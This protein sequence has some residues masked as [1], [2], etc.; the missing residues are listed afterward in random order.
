[1][2]GLVGAT[3]LRSVGCLSAA[4]SC[5]VSRDRRGATVF[6]TGDSN[7]L[8]NVRITLHIFRVLRPGNFR[9]G[10]CGRS[11]SGLMGNRV[12][13]RV[14]NGAEAVLGNREATLGLVRRVD[15]VT[16]TAGGTIRVIDNA[17]TSVTSAE[18]ALP[19][20]HPLRGCTIAIKNKEGRHCGLSSTTVLGSG[21]VSTNNK[22][23]G[24][25][26]GL[27]SG[28]NRVAGIRLRMEGLSRL[29]RTLRTNI[30]I[31]VLSGVDPRLV[32]RTISVAT[33]GTLLR[34]DNNVASRA[35]HRVTRANISVVSVNTLARSIGTFSVSLGVGW[36]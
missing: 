18:G 8:Y 32:G 12:V 27:G 14:R 6:L 34:T 7:I 23:T 10:I 9:T 36:T 30:S 15:N 13:T 31:V 22:V 4:A 5:L 19:N 29:G 28:L 3:L 11:N 20:V 1:M 26:S 25:I 33:N 16:A 24:T 2:S 35:L 17:G 21:R